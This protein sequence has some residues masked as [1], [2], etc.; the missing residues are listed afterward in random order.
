VRTANGGMR[1]SSRERASLE[2][3]YHSPNGSDEEQLAATETTLNRSLSPLHDGDP[4]FN[5]W[6]QTSLWWKQRET[7]SFWKSP[8]MSPL[9]PSRRRRAN[10]HCLRRFIRLCHYGPRRLEQRS[11]SR[12]HPT[13]RRALLAFYSFSGIFSVPNNCRCSPPPPPPPPFPP[14]TC[15]G[16]RGSL[17]GTYIFT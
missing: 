10:F 12:G 13:D 1:S 16:C 14:L 8:S 11:R 5:S 3:F 17:C 9:P 7:H 4:G 6:Q 2:A 15:R